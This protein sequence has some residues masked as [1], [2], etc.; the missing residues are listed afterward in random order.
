LLQAA[1][2]AAAWSAQAGRIATVSL[3]PA[4][5]G[6]NFCLQLLPQFFFYNFS[7]AAAAAQAGCLLYQ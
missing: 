7:V 5:A 3:C 6:Y 4:S 1:A 2:V